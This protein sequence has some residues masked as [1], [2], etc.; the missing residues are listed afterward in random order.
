MIFDSFFYAFQHLSLAFAAST[1]RDECRN[2]G[3]P[4][5]TPQHPPSSVKFEDLCP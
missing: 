5:L 2:K 4:L 3:L 1:N